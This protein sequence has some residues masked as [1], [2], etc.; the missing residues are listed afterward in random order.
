LHNFVVSRDFLTSLPNDVHFDNHVHF[1]LEHNRRAPGT[2]LPSRKR[3]KQHQKQ[4]RVPLS[5]EA[6]SKRT[7]YRRTEAKKR[8]AKTSLLLCV[9]RASTDL[10]KKYSKEKG[11]FT[12]LLIFS[13]FI[14]TTTMAGMHWTLGVSG[15]V[16]G[17]VWWS[18]RYQGSTWKFHASMCRLRLGQN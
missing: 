6:V 11:H 13:R 5:L 3:V 7:Y 9:C 8:T 16:V 2:R 10:S 15:E 17:R 18:I 14:F 12:D 1:D 4:P